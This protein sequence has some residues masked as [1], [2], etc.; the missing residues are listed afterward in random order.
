[1]KACTAREAF[2][3]FKPESCVFVISVEPDGRP[4]G[5]VAGWNMKCSWEP[6]LFAVSLSK[7]GYTHRLI[8]ESREFVVAVPNKHL[9]AAV[10]FFGSTHGNEVDKFKA[11]GIATVP[12]H[13]IRP[14]LL[15]DATIN[16]EC[17]LETEVD[18]GDHILFIGRVV[19]AYF[20]ENKKVLLNMGRW[21]GK[22]VFEEF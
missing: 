22:R 21:N 2:T 11:T 9:E 15:K 4:S 8:Q 18:S 12:A 19:A 3:R 5:M 20:D 14:P 13:H 7:N 6:P 10:E 16:M 1:M 17:V